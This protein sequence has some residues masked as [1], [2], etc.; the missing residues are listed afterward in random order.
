MLQQ[1]E[2]RATILA[3]LTSMAIGLTLVS[4]LGAFCFFGF[5][6]Q[7]LGAPEALI[8]MLFF[9]PAAALGFV[10]GRLALEKPL[11]TALLA[12]LI[13]ATFWSVLINVLAKTVDEAIPLYSTDDFLKTDLPSLLLGIVVAYFTFGV[14]QHSNKSFKA[15]A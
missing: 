7:V 15:D 12:G 10:A 5:S 14:R 11:V 9:V 13:S 3:F 6:E 2:L 8:N 1:M 4:I